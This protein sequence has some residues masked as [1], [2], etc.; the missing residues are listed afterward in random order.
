MYALMLL[1]EIGNLWQRSNVAIH[2]EDAIGDDHAHSS[3]ASL[4]Q[5]GLQCAP[6]MH[7]QQPL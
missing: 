7:D 5:L 3:R 1:A 2:R 4:G 6:F